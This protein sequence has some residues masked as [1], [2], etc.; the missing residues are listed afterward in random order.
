MDKRKR[1]CAVAPRPTPAAA[2]RFY[3]RFSIF[4][5]CLL[6]GC[7]APGDPKPRRPLV[8]EAVTDLAARQQGAGVLL[9]FTLPTKSTEGEPLAEPPTIEMYRGSVPAG[10]GQEKLSTQ[11]IL[12]VPSA[13]VETY[14]QE[15]Q[16]RFADSLKPGELTSGQ[17]V[18]MVRTRASKRR[19][20]AD[21][22]IAVVRVFPAPERVT[23][24][25]AVDTE[26]A[27]ELSWTPPAQIPASASL[28]GF[29]VY[30]SKEKAEPR[31]PDFVRSEFLARTPYPS[32]RDTD[33]EFGHAYSYSVST[34]LQYE[35]TEVESRFSEPV[36]VTPR[37]TFP[38]AAP[39]GLVAVLVP[40]TGEARVH[41]GLSW[42]L[43]SEEDWGGYRV[44]RG[45]PG[46]PSTS[47]AEQRITADLLAAP[48]FRDMSVE[49]GRRY[50]YRVTAVDR[51]GNESP[52]SSA[53]SVE[54]PPNEA[55]PVSAASVQ[56]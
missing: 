42:G 52:P 18:Y 55:L 25:R 10:A 6:V 39:Q 7:A 3:F 41:V 9:T 29:R 17:M 50:A 5:F 22:N 2:P 21:S 49:P 26:T 23:D 40:A 24:L 48:T 11:L 51:A 1:D 27:I 33:F 47:E 4:T 35:A 15:G 54:V 34:L 37:D 31:Y 36:R 19:A 32:Y 56:R 44:Y 16:V 46:H 45:E 8:P 13:M 28:A 20:S 14:L 12:T 43:N 53:V 30:R 38:P